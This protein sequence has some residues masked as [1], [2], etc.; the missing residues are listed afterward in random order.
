M[1][2]N[3]EF[4]KHH[5]FRRLNGTGEVLIFLDHQVLDHICF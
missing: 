5:A 2:A 3:L 1:V 4:Q